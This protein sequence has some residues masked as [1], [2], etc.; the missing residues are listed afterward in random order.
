M[1]NELETALVL[2]MEATL[3]KFEKQMAKARKA[4]RDTAKGLEDRFAKSNKAMAGNAEKSAQAIGREMDRLRAK[5]DPLFAASKRYENELDELN[6]AHKVG[7][8]NTRQYE[9]AL[10]RLNTNY[11]RATTAS[12]GVTTG[13]RGMRGGIQNVAFQVGDFA[14]QVGAGTSAS[15]ALGQQL[16]QLLGGFGAL[17]AVLGAVV[18]I[19]VPLAASMLDLG[20]GSETLKDKIEDL[21]EAV[22]DYRSAADNAIIPTDDLVEKYGTATTAA[23]EFLT[24]LQ[25]IGRV[26]AEEALAATIDNLTTKFGELNN[27]ENTPLEMIAGVTELK[28]TID[29]MSKALD[30]SKAEA[31]ELADGL[32]DLAAADGPAAQVRAADRLQERLIAV[33]GPYDD[34][35]TAQRDFYQSVVE[36]GETASELVGTTDQVEGNIRSA[37]DEA[38]RLSGNVS[39]I[40]FNAAIVAANEL[41][42]SLGVSAELARMIQNTQSPTGPAGLL[43]PTGGGSIDNGPGNT[44]GQGLT[45]DDIDLPGALPLPKPTRKSRKSGGGGSKSKK[46]GLFEGTEKQIEAL[47]QQIELIGKTTSEVAELKAKWDLLAEAKERGL[48]LDARQVATGETLSE[49]IERQAASVGNLTKQYEEAEAQAA[50]FDNQQQQLKEGLLDAIVEGENFAGVLED[51]AKSLAKAALQAALF[52]DGP[53]SGMFGGGGG[54][55]LLGWLFPN[56]KGNAFDGGRVTA[57]AKGGVVSQPTVFPMANGAG[58]MGEAG[59]EAVMPLA[60]LANGRLGVEAR[61]G[62][63]GGD[64]FNI[65]QSMSMAANGD[66]S[67][68]RILFSEFPKY[69]AMT[70]KK[71]MEARRRGG[72]MKSAFSG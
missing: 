13:L 30:I 10:E 51:V 27:T 1:A 31:R 44:Y 23:R 64:T 28:K 69:A 66:E 40:D 32:R 26:T 12:K 36:T 4:G 50:F 6:R 72:A 8:L 18:A 68:K 35:N 46:P 11:A 21:E 59:P 39:G 71:I 53:L 17:G 63:S 52:G 65:Y 34:M 41:A 25:E 70:E 48:D 67:V 55:G 47:K 54:G 42:E 14:T 45:V 38:A 22:N 49:Q 20:E 62:G 29:T 58:L 2:R 33:L 43:P 57:F 37:A 60:R 19:G 5:Y 3:T 9:A 56:A 61:G 16:P 15:I 7:A 24:A